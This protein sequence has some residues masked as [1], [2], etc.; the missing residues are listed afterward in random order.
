MPN[1]HDG[2]CSNRYSPGCLEPCTY[3]TIVRGVHRA[4]LGQIKVPGELM[5][6][7]RQ[8]VHFECR[9]KPKYERS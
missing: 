6:F 1:I 5:A 4:L 9:L 7:V 3:K 8:Q 2:Q